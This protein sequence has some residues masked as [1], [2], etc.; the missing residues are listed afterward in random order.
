MSLWDATGMLIN[1]EESFK[2]V[3]TDFKQESLKEV[4]PLPAFWI[5]KL[6]SFFYLHSDSNSSLLKL[7]DGEL[8]L[9][10]SE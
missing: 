3:S 2:S 8:S 4:L 9:L 1:L 7:K 10:K 5:T 6:F